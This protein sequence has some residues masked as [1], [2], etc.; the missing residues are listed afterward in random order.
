MTEEIES[1]KGETTTLGGLER[2]DR[3]LSEAQSR[4]LLADTK[5]C[6]KNLSG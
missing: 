5:K 6:A 2:S 1:G 3:R 4:Q